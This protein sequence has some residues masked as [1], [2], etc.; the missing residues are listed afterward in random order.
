MKYE[1]LEKD[2]WD[3]FYENKIKWFEKQGATR[4]T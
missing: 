3:L 4:K 2:L 1:G